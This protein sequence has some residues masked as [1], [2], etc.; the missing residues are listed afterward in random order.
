MSFDF[1]GGARARAFLCIQRHSSFLLHLYFFFVFEM[2]EKTIEQ[3]V[4]AHIDARLA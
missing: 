1:V 4:S 3:N 2:E